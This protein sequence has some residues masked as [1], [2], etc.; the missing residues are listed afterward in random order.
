MS[1]DPENARRTAVMQ[2][3]R[4]LCGERFESFVFIGKFENSDGDGTVTMH[5]WEG[6]SSTRP[7]G[8]LRASRSG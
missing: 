3:V 2:Q 5:T 7:S 6:L 4:D 1:N 8:S